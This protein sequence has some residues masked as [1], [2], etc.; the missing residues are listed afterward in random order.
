ML[1]DV[2]NQEK[3]KIQEVNSDNSSSGN[4]DSDSD[5]GEDDLTVNEKQILYEDINDAIN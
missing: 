4:T 5:P 1:K 2:K 3:D